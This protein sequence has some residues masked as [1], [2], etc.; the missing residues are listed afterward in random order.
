[1]YIL[2]ISPWRKRS[3][4]V[5]AVLARQASNFESLRGQ[6]SKN[7]RP[8]YL[9]IASAPISSK[10]TWHSSTAFL[11]SGC[12]LFPSFLSSINWYLSMHYVKRSGFSTRNDRLAEMR[13]ALYVTLTLPPLYRPRRRRRRGSNLKRDILRQLESVRS[14][15]C[16]F[17]L[18]N[19]QV[20]HK[21][22]NNKNAVCCIQDGTKL[23]L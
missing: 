3:T 15:W 6:G 16:L 4:S 14:L 19:V 13:Q 5:L 17:N 9:P 20:Q 10:H 8:L 22:H 12:L 11:I 2:D 7:S 18:Y 21:L 1:M 23:Q